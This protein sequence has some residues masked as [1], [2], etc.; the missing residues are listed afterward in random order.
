MIEQLEPPTDWSRFFL[1]TMPDGN[2]LW[3]VGQLRIIIE[4]NFESGIRCPQHHISFSLQSGNMPSEALCMK[5]AKQVRSGRW[6]VDNRYSKS[7]N[8][9][10]LWLL[11]PEWPIGGDEN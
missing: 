3:L 9:Q 10:H 1:G 5:M 4:T 7:K 2:R 11:D 8:I 6:E